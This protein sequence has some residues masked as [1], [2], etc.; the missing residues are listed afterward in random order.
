MNNAT[1]EVFDCVNGFWVPVA[2]AHI[3][4]EVEFINGVPNPNATKALS[5]I[6][7]LPGYRR[8]LDVGAN[9]GTFA[10]TL[11]QH[12]D[13]VEAFE[14]IPEFH[15]ALRLN[16]Q[17]FPGATA[18]HM[19]IGETSDDVYITLYKKKFGQLSH[20]ESGRYLT[21]KNQRVGPIQ[22]RSID[23]LHLD[24]V[25]LIKID[26]EGYEGPV[27]RG[28]R[29]TL[30]RCRPAVF[31]EQAGNEAKNFGLPENEAADFLESLGMIRHPKAPRM[32]KDRLYVFPER[33]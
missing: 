18:R 4:A 29:E 15:E 13:T 31:I 8:A 6:G 11:A 12:F 10:A 26:V 16:L 19:T 20:V 22:Q 32:S 3:Y 28:A 27:V 7:L 25:D 24:D 1:S 14:P 5:I 30:L 33:K 2:E 21:A 9:I 23:S 17:R